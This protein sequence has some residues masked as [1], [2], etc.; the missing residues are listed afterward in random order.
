MTV[1]PSTS[2]VLQRREGYRELRD[3]YLRLLLSPCVRWEGLEQL[4]QVPS[5][6]VPT[7][8]EY[9]CFFALADV[10][11]RATGICPDWRDFVRFN[12][13]V[14][15][16]RIQRGIRARLRIGP[17][18][19]WYNRGFSRPNSYSLP[20]R[21]DYTI[22]IEGRCLLFDA[23]YRLEWTEL[24]AALQEEEPE[25]TDREATFRRADLYKMHTY[26]DAIRGARAVFILY[27]GTEFSAFGI[28]EKPYENP[29]DLSP[30]FA[31]VGAVPVRPG[32]T[33]TLEAVVRALLRSREQE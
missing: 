9:W 18:T 26:R 7:L 8:Y 2:Q 22:E 13:D 17:A 21:P 32:Q 33:G 10:L 15:E 23:K 25:E 12:R 27:P 30:G 14:W 19:L 20:L 5:R 3:A 4:L 29:Q 16:V 28:T 24:R 1:F 31:G 6:D 11:S